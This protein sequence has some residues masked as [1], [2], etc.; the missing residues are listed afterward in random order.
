MSVERRLHPLLIDAIGKLL[1]PAGEAW[2]SDPNRTAAE[3]F[4]LHAVEAGFKV[5]TVYM[6][7]ESFAG[8]KQ[9]G[10]LYILRRG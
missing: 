10:Q 8:G 4:P 9:E 1:A 6:E 2:V 7:G 3:D 5:Q